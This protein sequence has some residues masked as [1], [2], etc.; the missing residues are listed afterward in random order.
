MTSSSRPAVAADADGHLAERL[1]PLAQ[2]ARH[3]LDDLGQRGERGLGEHGVRGAR[4]L[5]Q[6]E[7]H[8][9]GL[10]V[11]E[12]QRRQPPAGAEGVAAVAPGGALDRV[13]EVAQSGHVPAQRARRDLEPRRQLRRRPGRTRREQH[14]QSQQPGGG[15]DAA[16]FV[17]ERGP[18][19]STIVRTFV[20]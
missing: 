6:P 19:L 3:H 20:M 14:E 18:E 1:D 9:D 12:Q 15:V 8:G 4:Q 7:R 17:T 11:V 10:V 2:R 13:T 16:S 5:A